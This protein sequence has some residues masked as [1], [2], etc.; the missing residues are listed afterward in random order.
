MRLLID[1]NIVVDFLRQRRPFDDLARLLM[2]I[3]KTGDFELWI[4]P[5]QLGDL[6]YILTKGGKANLAGSVSEELRG[7]CN[8]V[9]VCTFGMPELVAALDDAW[10]DIEDALVYEAAMAI[11][12]DA[13]ITR[14]GKD[15]SQSKIPVFNCDELFD[16]YAQE[17]GI[18]YAE[19]AF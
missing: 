8:F 9:N 12:A 1:T 2:A 6:V 15:F 10:P 5:S 14:N 7:L 11:K 19:M 3:G 18:E 17:Y 4:S 16:W 13:I